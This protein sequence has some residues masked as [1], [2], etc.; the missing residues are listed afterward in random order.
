MQKH[1][2]EKD[3]MEVLVMKTVAHKLENNVEGWVSV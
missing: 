2:A 3:Q 1:Q